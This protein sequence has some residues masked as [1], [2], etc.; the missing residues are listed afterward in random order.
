MASALIPGMERLSET[1]RQDVSNSTHLWVRS[2]EGCIVGKTCLV[3]FLVLQCSLNCFSV[4]KWP[5][6]LSI[7][8][9]DSLLGHL[10][11]DSV[12]FYRMEQNTGGKKLI[13]TYHSVQLKNFI[14]KYCGLRRHFLSLCL[15][16][17]H[18]LQSALYMFIYLILTIALAQ[19][20]RGRITVKWQQRQQ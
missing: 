4:E 3:S 20:R 15:S 13:L 11:G 8:F 18:R 12:L 17:C 16:L 1:D 10:K 6:P 19:Q 9:P 5:Q 14:F 7:Q 2:D